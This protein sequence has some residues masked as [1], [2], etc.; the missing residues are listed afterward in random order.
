MIHIIGK[1]L[2]LVVIRSFLIV[3]ELIK[4]L[5]SGFAHDIQLRSTGSANAVK[6]IRLSPFLTV[7]A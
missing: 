4:L 5:Y 7:S 3:Q 1:G 6:E 2:I